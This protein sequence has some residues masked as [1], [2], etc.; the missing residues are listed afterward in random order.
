MLTSKYLKLSTFLD[1]FSL[2]QFFSQLDYVHYTTQI[3][4]QIQ[5]Q[6]QVS[7]LIKVLNQILF[8]LTVRQSQFEPPEHFWFWKSSARYTYVMLCA[9]YFVH[10]KINANWNNKSLE[11]YQQ[12]LIYTSCSVVCIETHV[13]TMVAKTTPQPNKFL[14]LLGLIRSWVRTFIHWIILR[15]VFENMMRRRSSHHWCELN[16]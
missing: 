10:R 16:V 3:Q 12:I 5:I 13:T 6:I 8:K 15:S 7:G 4:I 11:S 14:L 1:K 9:N 2:L